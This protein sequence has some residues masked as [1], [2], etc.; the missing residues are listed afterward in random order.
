M[1]I[2]NNLKVDAYVLNNYV[3]SKKERPFLCSFKLTYDCNLTCHQCPFHMMQ[4][5]NPSFEQVGN[6]LEELHERG[7]RIVVFEGGEPMLWKDKTYSIHDVVKSAKKSFFSVGM[8][9]N[10]TLPL[11]VNTDILWFSIDGLKDTHNNLRNSNV[12]DKVID[13]VKKSYHPK[14]FA[15]ITANRKNYSEIPELVKLLPKNVKGIT[16]QFYYPYNN[17]DDLFLEF[18]KR[19]KLL[20]EII[21]LKRGGYKIMNSYSGLEAMKKNNWKCVDWL[22]DNANPDGTITNGCYLKGRSDM[23]C[24]KCGFSPHVEVSLAYKGDLEAIRSGVSIFFK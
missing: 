24:K 11:D 20:E 5:K 16:L 19:E 2:I 12:F 14:L 23:D 18:D 9:T 7:N 13:N 8:T 15:H 22:V 4:S 21:A 3:L 10:G 17:N 1:K 6:V